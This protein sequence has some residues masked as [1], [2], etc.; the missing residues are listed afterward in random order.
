MCLLSHHRLIAP[1]SRF[2][3]RSPFPPP[4]SQI[5]ALQQALRAMRSELTALRARCAREAMTALPPLIVR[6]VV[7][8]DHAV[9]AKVFASGLVCDV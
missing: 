7:P 6:A 9:V 5:E 3:H 2:P 4:S 8:D 1:F